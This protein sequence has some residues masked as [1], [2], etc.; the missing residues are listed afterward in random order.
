MLL[1]LSQKVLETI[2]KENCIALTHI[3][4][5]ISDAINLKFILR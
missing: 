2:Y 3:R 5:N 1:D 4:V